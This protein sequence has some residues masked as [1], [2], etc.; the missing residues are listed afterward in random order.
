MQL[1]P[2]AAWRSCALSCLTAV[3][4]INALSL[5]FTICAGALLA[6]LILGKKGRP[7][8]AAVVEQE[9]LR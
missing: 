5:I 1:L 7:G 6:F 3:N 4:L 2:L 9:L 8:G